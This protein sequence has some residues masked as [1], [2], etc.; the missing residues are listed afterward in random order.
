MLAIK[1]D[2]HVSNF[3]NENSSVT[4]VITGYRCSQTRVYT[5]SVV[6][7]PGLNLYIKSYTTGMSDSSALLTDTRR[8]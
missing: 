3:K 5:Q 8:L 2:D 6:S 4:R 7:G 1:A